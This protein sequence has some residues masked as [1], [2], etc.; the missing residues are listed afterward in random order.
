LAT[1]WLKIGLIDSLPP[2]NWSDDPQLLQRVID[3]LLQCKHIQYVHF[4]GGETLITPAF[5]IILQALI[6]AGLNKSA[7][8]GFTTNLSVWRSDIVELLEQFKSVNL[9]MSVESFD[10]VNDYVRW[11]VTL[12]TVMQNIAQ[13]QQVAAKNSWLLQFRI[14]PTCLTVGKMLPI[15]DYAWQHKITVESCDFLQHPKIMKPSVLPMTYRQPIIHQMQQWID[16]HQVQ[17]ET[18]VNI[19]NP[20]TV[21][22]QLIQDLGSYVAYLSQESDYS[23]LMPELVQFLQKIERSRNNSILSYLPEYEELFRSAGY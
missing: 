16:Q 17:S 22:A 23:E 1:E 15:Y 4:I 6:D 19:R 11:P 20:N 13:W 3:T 8:V 14:T 5:K 18:V 7:T 9:G 2:N 10:A 21:S 12:S